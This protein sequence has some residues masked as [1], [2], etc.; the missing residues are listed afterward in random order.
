MDLSPLSIVIV[1]I[2]MIGGVVYYLFGR[3][4]K[5]SDEAPTAQPTSSYTQKSEY[6]DLMKPV[7]KSSAR[8]IDHK[9]IEGEITTDTVTLVSKLTYSRDEFYAWIDIIDE[10]HANPPTDRQYDKIQSWEYLGGA[11]RFDARQRQRDFDRLIKLFRERV[12]EIIA[13]MSADGWSSE[14]SSDS[15]GKRIFLLTRQAT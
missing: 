1:V 14:L 7:A 9:Q 10:H 3:R 11:D 6:A 13:E 15:N 5:P 8:L 12:D 4:N 2:A